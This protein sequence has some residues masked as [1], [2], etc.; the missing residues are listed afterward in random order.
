MARRTATITHIRYWKRFARG[1]DKAKDLGYLPDGQDF[2]DYIEDLWASLDPDALMDDRRQRYC[3]PVKGE[4]IRRGRTLTLVAEVGPYGD[5]ASLKDVQT[6]AERYHHDGDLSHV[7]QVRVMF[8]V[9]PSATSAL[10][11]VEHAAEGSLGT[12]LL[13]ALDEAWAAD[14]G[15]WTLDYENLVHPAAWLENAQLQEV[16]AE[17]WGWTDVADAG[18]PRKLG[19]VVSVLRPDGG[20]Y[21]PQGILERLTQNKALAQQLLGLKEPPGEVKVRVGNGEQAKTYVVGEEKTPP[22]RL[23]ITDHGDRSPTTDGFRGWSVGQLPE[24]FNN[25]GVDWKHGWERDAA[26]TKQR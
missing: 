19:R 21:L 6:A 16:Q 8:A 10:M 3:R 5:P 26:Q 9:P 7:V 1:D 13:W 4:E 18:V 11:F 25:V 22:V 14:F 12:R 15:E 2:L 23:L 17:S 20:G 24:Y